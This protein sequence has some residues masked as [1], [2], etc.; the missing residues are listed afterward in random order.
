[1]AALGSIFYASVP[2]LVAPLAGFSHAMYVLALVSVPVFAILV[3]GMP[4]KARDEDT[5]ELLKAYTDIPAEV[6]EGPGVAAIDRRQ[7][8]AAQPWTTGQPD[9]SGR[10]GITMYGE[11][12]ADRVH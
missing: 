5:I 11:C 1:M 12:H 2:A 3:F 6:P 10:A 4:R 8:D 9:N 7:P